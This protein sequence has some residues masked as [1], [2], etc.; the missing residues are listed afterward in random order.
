MKNK[1][2]FS[3][4]RVFLA[5]AHN[6]PSVCEVAYE[7][8]HK[9]TGAIIQRFYMPLRKHCVQRM[10]RAAYKILR[11]KFGTFRRNE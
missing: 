9:D 4:S 7:L 10:C 3:I 5:I 1:K 6:V 2:G 11:M 8:A